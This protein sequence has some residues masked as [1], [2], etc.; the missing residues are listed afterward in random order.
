MTRLWWALGLVAL[1][2]SFPLAYLVASALPLGY[3]FRAY[4][5]A[6]Q[7]IVTGARVYEP[8][9]AVLGQPDEFHYLPIVAVPFIATL[10]MPLDVAIRVW[11]VSQIALAA[12]LGVWLVRQVP[13]S[14]RTRRDADH[15]RTKYRRAGGLASQRAKR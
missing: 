9:D 1:V 8:V 10:V 5:L 4:W 13:S 7:H 12:G 6:A 2:L 11:L 3:D 14:V 15:P